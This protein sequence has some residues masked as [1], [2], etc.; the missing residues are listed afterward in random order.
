[1][2]RP[3]IGA[4]VSIAGGFPKAIENINE[5]T[6]TCLQAFSK[7]PRTWEKPDVKKAEKKEFLEA[8]EKSCVAPL[9]FHAPYLINLAKD[10]DTGKKSIEVLER[11]L[12]V[13]GDLGFAGSVIHLGSYNNDKT[14]AKH[15]LLIKN[16]KRIIDNTPRNTKFIIENMGTRKIGKDLE[17]IGRIIRDVGSERLRVCLDTCH[18]HAAGYDITTYKKLDEFLKHF[19]KE[20]G[21]DRLELIHANDSKDEFGSLRDRHE[22]IGEG[23]I[24]KEVFKHLLNHPKTK[25][26]PF[27]LET[28]GFDDRGPDLKNVEIL[29]ECA[30]K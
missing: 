2:S 19:D 11:E 10:D 16:I 27:I 3:N 24:G 17:E 9:Y 26:L 13:A 7:S 23:K 28:P 15:D 18:L 6:G 29:R 1:M 12:E 21:L 14:T 25:K 4:H 5:I 30:G 20:I 22:N 8:V